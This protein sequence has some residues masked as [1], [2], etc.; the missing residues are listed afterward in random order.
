MLVRHRFTPPSDRM[1][2]ATPSTTSP[3]TAVERSL[4]D[5]LLVSEFRDVYLYAFSRRTIL[6]D[7]TLRINHPLPVVT[8]S[9]ILKNTDSFSELLRDPGAVQQQ[10]PLSE[11]DYDSDSDLDEFEVLGIED[12]DVSPTGPGP[13]SAEESS[14]EGNSKDRTEDP[15]NDQ[16]AAKGSTVV[17]TQRYLQ[18]PIPN[19][20][21][22]TLRACVFYLYT[23]KIDFLP[24]TSSGAAGKWRLLR[25]SN[26]LAPPCSPKSMYRL[27]D[28]YG[29]TELRD[30][31]YNEVVSQLRPENILEEAF[32]SFF[33]RYDRLREHAISFLCRNYY[34]SAVQESFPD[35]IQRIALGEMPHASGV[36]RSLLGLPAVI[37]LQAWGRVPHSRAVKRAHLLGKKPMPPPLSADGLKPQ[38]TLKLEEPCQPGIVSDV[39]LQVGVAPEPVPPTSESTPPTAPGPSSSI[40]SSTPASD[41]IN[42]ETLQATLEAEPAET[43]AMC[44]QC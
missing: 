32:S 8:I 9:S 29:L 26:D 24:L 34:T 5:S 11:Y 22:K 3:L 28:L 10:A 2:P 16:A 30:L 17:A 33:V 27:A 6:P 21:Y 39:S 44:G 37:S 4:R 15:A 41:S 36:L 23:G 38:S 19:I 43:A 7:G 18:V 12:P 31:A 14:P 1:G 42:G 20:A 13:V 40:A 25:P 35:I